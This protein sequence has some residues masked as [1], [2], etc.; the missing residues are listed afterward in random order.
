MADWKNDPA[1][2][3]RLLAREATHNPAL[4]RRIAIVD[5]LAR[6]GFTPWDALVE[7]VEQDVGPGVFGLSP[8]T[9][10]W[11]DLRALR[12]AGIAIGYSRARGTTGYFL[13]LE[14]LPDPVQTAIRQVMRELDFEHLDRI[15]EFSGPQRIEAMFALTDFIRDVAQA[16]Q[17]DREQRRLK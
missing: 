5:V 16:G 9:R 13:K 6:R 10:L 4:R 14:A 3:W 8:Q 1:L 11:R 12:D 17:Q 7:A 2:L 15:A